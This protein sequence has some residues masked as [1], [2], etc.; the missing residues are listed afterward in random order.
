MTNSLKPFDDHWHHSILGCEPGGC[1]VGQHC[2]ALYCTG[3]PECV[4]CT[5]GCNGYSNCGLGK[6][7]DHGSGTCVDET[8]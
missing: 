6:K 5:P 1:P 4:I 2:P 7:C 3:K 8:F